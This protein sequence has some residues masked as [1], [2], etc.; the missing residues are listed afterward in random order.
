MNEER[1]AAITFYVNVAALVCWLCGLFYR[2]I[3]P[4]DSMILIF[5]IAMVIIHGSMLIY[6]DIGRKEILKRKNHH[7]D[8]E[9][10]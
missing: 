5:I 4:L 10:N 7:I 3:F 1:L 6:I 8:M 9:E 2:L